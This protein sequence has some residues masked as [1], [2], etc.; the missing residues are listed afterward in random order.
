[1]LGLHLVAALLITIWGVA[2]DPTRG[3]HPLISH[4]MESVRCDCARGSQEYRE[5]AQTSLME[6]EATTEASSP[7]R[8]ATE[9]ILIETKQPTP[10]ESHIKP[11][12]C[13]FKLTWMLFNMSVGNNPMISMVYFFVLYPYIKSQNPHY[14][15]EGLDINLHGINTLILILEFCFSAIPVR[16]LHVIYPVMFGLVYVIFSVIYWSLNTD[17]NALYPNVLDWNVPAISAV[18]VCILACVVLP[19]IQLMWY[20]IYRLRHHI[21]ERIYKEDL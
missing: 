11:M 19:L 6:S 12:P 9:D 20:G 17:D 7:D 3:G 4:K 5:Q 18:V 10:P 1:M 14:E 2:Y 13:H 15:P 16:L 21:Y 8:T